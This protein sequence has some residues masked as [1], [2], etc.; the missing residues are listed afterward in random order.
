[1]SLISEIGAVD[2]VMR[3]WN[4][5]R[6]LPW[7]VVER[8]GAAHIEAS[9]GNSVM[10]RIAKG[11]ADLIVK[12]VNGYED[13]QE[14]ARVAD[15]VLRHLMAGLTANDNLT[16]ELSLAIDDVQDGAS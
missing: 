9:N 12:A 15:E 14:R 6:P 5:P 3:T 16:T 11:R 7:R 13:A 4:D 1:M 8:F 10:E 2:P